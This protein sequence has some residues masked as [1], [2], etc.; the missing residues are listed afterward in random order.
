MCFN[1]SRI[2]DFFVV[3]LVV[4][5]SEV[6]HERGFSKLRASRAKNLWV[7]P[8]G[9]KN[10]LN[11]TLS[12]L[13]FFNCHCTYVRRQWIFN[14]LKPSFPT[15]PFEKALLFLPKMPHDYQE[16]IK[17]IVVNFDNFYEMIKN[18]I[19]KFSNTNCSMNYIH[20][21]S[22]FVEI[23]KNQLEICVWNFSDH[24]IYHF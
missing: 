10:L 23:L 22:K 15:L 16:K 8:L 19:S 12:T 24:K 1:F 11:F 14:E 13:K 4:I 3:G 6:L 17:E 20:F 5:F 18:E 21:P 2:L 7:S 9:W